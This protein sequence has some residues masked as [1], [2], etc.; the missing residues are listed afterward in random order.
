MQNRILIV[1]DEEK[2]LSVVVEFLAS[3]GFLIDSAQTA[4]IALSKFAQNNYD[5]IVLDWML[6][7]KPGIELIKEIRKTSDL[8]VIFLTAKSNE[9]DKLVGLEL[10]A[11]DY[12][13]K[14]FS[15]RELAARIRVILRRTGR[16]QSKS[17]YKLFDLE[18]EPDNFIVKRGNTEIP[19]TPSEFKILKLLASDPGRVF[20]R[21]QL[22][23]V[24]LGESYEGYERSIDTHISNL[25][26]KLSQDEYQYIET[27]HGV[28]YRFLRDNR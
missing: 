17:V 10:G 12:I 8:P 23:E 27:V 5:L 13:T 19:L 3:E 25:R 26:K 18:I 15:I 11:D 1:D 6:P 22:V 9:I 2:L 4:A 7:D 28:G 20:T 24:V 14:P 21:L 16:N